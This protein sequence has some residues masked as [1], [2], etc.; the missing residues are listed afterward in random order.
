MSLFYQKAISK[1]VSKVSFYFIFIYLHLFSLMP[2]N[3]F[4][5]VDIFKFKLFD[6][7]STFNAF[8]W[9]TLISCYLSLFG[10]YFYNILIYSTLVGYKKASTL[11]ILKNLLFLLLDLIRINIKLCD[12]LVFSQVKKVIRDQPF[13]Y[14][15]LKLVFKPGRWRYIYHLSCFCNQ[16]VN[17]HIL[18]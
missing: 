13:I 1:R 7:L 18:D 2:I 15:L 8:T 9:F 12:N 5:L 6:F 4:F 10:V 11:N 14:S 16:S 17:Y 3:F